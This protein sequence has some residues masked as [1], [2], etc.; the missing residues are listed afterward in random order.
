MSIPVRAYEAADLDSVV[1]IWREIGWIDDTDRQ[2]EALGHFM[3]IGHSN[4]ALI[5]GAAECMV[6]W[7]PGSIRYESTDLPLCAVT[8]VTTSRVGRK[9]DL[10]SRMTAMALAEGAAAGCA[11]AAL[12]M[13][14]QGFYDR[15]GF[16][17][18]SYEHV[19]TLDPNSLRVDTPYRSPVRLGTDDWRDIH[20]A[21]QS[22]RRTH[23]AVCL[24]PAGS[25]RADLGFHEKP[26][27]LGYRDGDGRL[28]HFL[29]GEAK[30]EHGPY[31]VTWMGYETVHQLMELL[32]LMRELGDQIASV[33]LAEPA[34]F[35]LQDLVTK[36]VR[37]E[38][39][40]EGSEHA[41]GCRAMA[42]WQLRILDLEA[43]VAARCWDGPTVAF[44]LRL[45]DPL[46]GRSDLDWS[47]VGG[48]YTVTVGEKS[49][50]EPGHGGLPRLETTVNAFSRMWF[51]VRPATTLSMT[52]TLSA[53]V[54]LLD[55]L[56]RALLLPPPVPGLNF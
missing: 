6:H 23:G 26:F 34:G 50:I 45:T 47:G 40:S 31:E 17:S 11:V 49:T 9:L 42:W 51:G 29:F 14:E 38:L 12:G 39:R 2:A 36:P 24:D 22:R 37:Q 10:A 30:G 5:D 1:R 27:G 15:V 33:K 52:D 48:D 13:F 56:D 4:V 18:G 19:F 32:R 3:E 43:C 44:D 46:A 41:T 8:A 25:V 21:M 35:Q 7:T 53:P 20:A 55:Q 54:E 28:T 16:G